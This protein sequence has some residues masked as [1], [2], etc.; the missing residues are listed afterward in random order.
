MSVEQHIRSFR[1]RI[2]CHLRKAE[3]YSVTVSVNHH[4]LDSAKFDQ[5]LVG[6]SAEA[7]GL[8]VAVASYPVKG[9][10]AQV[11]SRK[12]RIP[13]SQVYDGIRV[14]VKLKNLFKRSL[15]L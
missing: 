4:Y 13:V 1:C 7:V 12:I 2:R 10:T 5:L 6:E 11:T 3:F 9:N 8:L 15:F 14:T